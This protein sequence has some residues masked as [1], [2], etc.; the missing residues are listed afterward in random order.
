MYRIDYVGIGGV[1]R[2]GCVRRSLPALVLRAAIIGLIA[3]AALGASSPTH[4]AS[5]GTID[6]TDAAL[7][8]AFQ[9]LV[10]AGG[11]SLRFNC[12]GPTTIVLSAS[13]VLD[14]DAA[15]TIDGSD[16]GRND[17]I[18][19]GGGVVQVF[20]LTGKG[21]SLTLQHIQV[22]H[23]KVAAPPAGF[24]QAGGDGRGGA[25]FVAVDAT[26]IASN[27]S[28]TGN[29]ALGGDGDPAIPS[30][31]LAPGFNGG[32]GG[33]ALGGAIY[34]EGTLSLIADTFAANVA[35]S[36]AGAAGGSGSPG[37]RGDDGSSLSQTYGHDGTSGQPG[38]NGAAG[39][40]AQ[41]GAIYNAGTLTMSGSSF[42]HDAATAGAGG[43]GGTGGTGGAG[44]DGYASAGSEFGGGASGAN[45]GAGGAGAN[46]GPATGGAIY[47]VG[48]LT[49]DASTTLTANRATGGDGGHGGSSGNG[50]DGGAGQEAG[51][52]GPGGV[53][54]SA[55]AGGPAEG[56]GLYTKVSKLTSL[57][58]CML[59]SN[60]ADGG[61][62]GAGGTAGFG[63][64]AGTAKGGGAVARGGPGGVGGN[65]AGGGYAQGG[66]VAMEGI[67]GLTAAGCILTGNSSLGGAGGAGGAGGM[68]NIGSAANNNND[69]AGTGG[70]GGSGGYGGGGGGSA[71]G[72]LY[73]GS[74]GAA[75]LTASTL[76][77]NRAAAGTAGTGGAGGAGFAGHVGG[78]GSSIVCSNGGDGGNG[79]VAG[80]A[81]TGGGGNQAQGGGAAAAAGSVLT[82]D[83]STVDD[84]SVSGGP[85]G[86]GGSG[87]SGGAGGDD[88]G[89]SSYC[90]EGN[91]GD[92]GAGSTGG[93]SGSMQ[94]A[95]SWGGGIASAGQLTLTNSTISGNTAHN[96]G[97]G[98][99]G[100]G[101]AGG[102][103]GAGGAGNVQGDGGSGGAGGDGQPGVSGQ[104]GDLFNA[105]T[106][107]VT[108]STL[109]DGTALA[110]SS[111]AGGAGGA[112]GGVSALGKS[113]PGQPGSAGAA[114]AAGPATGAA[115]GGI[116]YRQTG[117]G[118]RIANSLVAKGSSAACAGPG[119][120]SDLGNN[121]EYAGGEG[122][123]GFSL[124]SDRLG[125]PRLL[126]LA[127]NGGPTR[128]AALD[129][130]SAAIA[131]GNP[132]VCQ[133]N[134][135]AGRDQ[136]GFSRPVGSCD[137][138]A[139]DSG[140]SMQ[141]VTHLV[142]A[143]ATGAF[144][145]AVTLTATLTS[146]GTAMAGGNVSF[147]LNGVAVG[148]AATT[149]DGVATLP[150]ASLAGIEAGIY[151]TGI[152]AT[153]A[154]GPTAAQS[155][156]QAQLVVQQASQV[157]SF[158]Q[159]HAMHAGD[160]PQALRAS[161]SSGLHPVLT[162]APQSDGVC[163]IVQ[164]GSGGQAVP[165]YSVS[166][167]GTGTCTIIAA[168]PGDTDYAAAPELLR[169]FPV[170]LLVHTTASLSPAI[171]DGWS[172][173]PVVVSL[174][175][176]GG[177]GSSKTYYSVDDPS[178][179]PN[180]TGT[181]TLYGFA[182]TVAEQGSHVVYFFSI[183]ATGEQEPQQRI[184]VRLDTIAP[185]T[186]VSLSPAQPA[187][188]RYAGPV[189]VTLNAVDNLNGSG[190]SSTYYSIDDAQ[191]GSPSS[192]ASSFI[193]GTD[194]FAVATPGHHILTYFSKDVAGN[195]GLAQ[196]VAFTVNAPDLAIHLH[197]DSAPRHGSTGRYRVLIHNVGQ[198]ATDGQV[199]VTL[200][201]SDGA[202]IAVA[203][204][205]LG[206]W[207]CNTQLRLATC[208][209]PV[210]D[211]GALST[212]SIQTTLD[213]A[214]SSVLATA[215]VQTPYDGNSRNDTAEVRTHIR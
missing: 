79:G 11:G 9:D 7:H 75:L 112:A 17:L 209:L 154:G 156:G 35:A 187:E 131:A 34:N 108:N 88:G 8:T 137:I 86:G 99:G 194:T 124:A 36:G 200:Q 37:L 191:C 204:P 72:G 55:G 110:G 180:A 94:A 189:Q 29:A 183:D 169:S 95:V 166:A 196:T 168:Q 207:Q 76:T 65:G 178:C 43:T 59:T 1:S 16:Q 172:T 145:G 85:S 136:R 41:G 44:G 20:R 23:G 125:D 81:G 186:T 139:Y 61:A 49:L 73:D 31:P 96:I 147:T 142:V 144:G 182:P 77:S 101:G 27:S 134:P 66:A 30:I 161:A 12:A 160:P 206:R 121:L 114:G 135:V 159:P 51:Q 165:A 78:A 42:S 199:T 10:A 129:T 46:G 15:I 97:A 28:F 40:A 50:G 157:I 115:Q 118:L 208:S 104:G 107:A 193:G 202:T 158:D 80:P 177:S 148:S 149:A 93:R 14:T 146:N 126:P 116:V 54:G 212:F 155:T 164:L 117:S 64:A 185:T 22:Q 19:D 210:M 138:G 58:S 83:S 140:A 197:R 132:L 205:Y 45:G 53:S 141:V 56:G 175:T 102:T 190:L 105:G 52:A 63:G 113:L 111:S 151:P 184:S 6:C 69:P 24:G 2:V 5:E 213:S 173:I 162:I 90:S 120:S 89:A 98:V 84:N 32:Q 167:S 215:Q 153:F 201:L 70:N 214:A 150:N 100:A 62:G 133:G 170:E 152:A 18:I 21:A 68:G 119:T 60:S 192:C 195:L 74:I 92:G 91:G 67:G 203:Q 174:S 163:A 130:G 82:L 13:L 38:G 176:T 198:G 211:R 122:S 123:C 127:D 128:T 71:G 26:L 3:L 109:N 143:A 87:G 188:G 25:A 39:G 57:A 48:T 47:N 181:C 33:S 106:L 179:T 4:A 171:G 103:G